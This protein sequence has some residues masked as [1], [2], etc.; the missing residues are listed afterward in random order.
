MKRTPA[1]RATRYAM[2]NCGQWHPGTI[3]RAWLAGHRSVKG[4][5]RDFM[6]HVRAQQT[7]LIEARTRVAQ[8][9]EMVRCDELLTARAHIVELTKLLG[10]KRRVK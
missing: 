4:Q 3:T 7:A 8:L 10:I 9:E 2:A 6:K 5:H 1:Q